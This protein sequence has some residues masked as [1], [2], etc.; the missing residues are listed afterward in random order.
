MMSANQVGLIV[1]TL[2]RLNPTAR[3]F[4]VQRDTFSAHTLLTEGVTDPPTKI[5]EVR[6][7]LASVDHDSRGDNQRGNDVN[8]HLVDTTRRRS[9]HSH[10][11]SRKTS[12]GQDSVFGLRR[13]STGTEQRYVAARLGCSYSS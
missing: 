7:W 6:R 13:C 11:G 3:I 9:A 1:A 12:T 4:D 5:A 10:G 8:V 2:R